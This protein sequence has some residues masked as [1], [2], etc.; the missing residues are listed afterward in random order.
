MNLQSINLQ[1]IKRMETILENM[2]ESVLSCEHLTCKVTSTL[3]MGFVI[4]FVFSSWSILGLWLSLLFGYF[5]MI[6]CNSMDK[7][8]CFSSSMFFGVLYII[9]TFDE[10]YYAPLWILLCY[11]TLNIFY[12]QRTIHSDVL[13][14]LKKKADGYLASYEGENQLIQ[15]IAELVK[16]YKMRNNPGKKEQ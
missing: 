8:H 6:C 9:L 5:T 11:D 4:S 10:W 16:Q 13:S 1:G 14:E 12:E 2:V 15:R 7:L 3:A